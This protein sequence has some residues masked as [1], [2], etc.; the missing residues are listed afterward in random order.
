MNI[1]WCAIIISPLN[2]ILNSSNAIIIQIK[3]PSQQHSY[4][5]IYMLFNVLQI[6]HFIAMKADAICDQPSSTDSTDHKMFIPR[7]FNKFSAIIISI[8][9]NLLIKKSNIEKNAHIILWQC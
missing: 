8:E 2:L 1:K 4:L 7:Y 9:E 6:F 3:M 5:N